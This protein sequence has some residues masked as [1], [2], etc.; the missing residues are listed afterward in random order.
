M[1]LV[2]LDNTLYDFAAAMERASQAVIALIGRGDPGDLIHTLIFSPHGVESNQALVEYLNL[3]GIEGGQALKSACDEF[4]LIKN[5]NILPFPGV[6]AGLKEIHRSGILIAAVTNASIH[7][8]EERLNLIKV[9]NLFHLIITPEC[10]GKKKP[11]PKV[12]LQAA[13]MVNCPPSRICVIGDNLVNDIAPAQVIGMFAIHAR[14]GDRL[15]AEFAGDVIPD[16]VVDL[17]EDVI[18]ILGISSH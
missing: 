3:Q 6:V 10:T 5:Q 18:P 8:A 14:Y 9:R 1:L 11:D 16:A 15:P 2:D 17:F 13:E 7:R 4:A 12:F